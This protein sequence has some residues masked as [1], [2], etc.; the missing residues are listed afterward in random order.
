MNVVTNYYPITLNRSAIEWIQYEVTV[1]SARR[2]REKDEKT[3]KIIRD[4]IVKNEKRVKHLDLERGSN[5]LC[6]RVLRKLADDENLDF[7]TD[8]SKLVYSYK[9]LFEGEER[10]FVVRSVLSDCEEDDVDA[11]LIKKRS[12]FIVTLK[13]TAKLIATQNNLSD[14]KHA[15]EIIIKSAM[16][17]A[18]MKMFGRNSQV[19]FYPEEFQKNFFNT[20]KLRRMRMTVSNEY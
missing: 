4:E 1:H 18:G 5:Q 10:E 6:R 13:E 14:L 9:P 2:V 7:A 3:G 15:M 16:L 8:G 17:F 20:D 12:H 11:E 19:F